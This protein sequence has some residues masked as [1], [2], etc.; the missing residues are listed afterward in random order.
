VIL[1]GSLVAVVAMLVSAL[2]CLSEAKVAVAA[3]VALVPRLTV[4]QHKMEPPTLEAAAGELGAAVHRHK[5]VLVA[6]ES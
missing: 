2:L 4:H 6:Q 5:L 1:G 3:V